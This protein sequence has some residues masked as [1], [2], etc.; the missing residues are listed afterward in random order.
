MNRTIHYK[1][2]KNNNQRHY[3]PTPQSNLIQLRMALGSRTIEGIS[4]EAGKLYLNMICSSID[5]VLYPLSF[6]G[7]LGTEEL[8]R[9]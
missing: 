3:R 6:I 8:A 4:I 2:K 5:D 1:K 9:T 7:M